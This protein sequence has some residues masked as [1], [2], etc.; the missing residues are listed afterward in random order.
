LK[1]LYLT[2]KLAL[3]GAETLLMGLANAFAGE[4]GFE[5]RVAAA[6]GPLAGRFDSRVG[7]HSITEYSAK[8]APA[9]ALE[10]RRILGETRPD[11]VHAHGASIGALCAA[12]G[13]TKT[14]RAPVI[15]TDHNRE[16][17]RLR[18]GLAAGVMKLCFARVVA[19]SEAKYAGL[20]ALGIPKRKLARIPNFVDCDSV[21][22][23]IAAVDAAAV[24][25]ELGIEQGEP[26]LLTAGR[27]L[28][29]KR[30]DR[31]IE[32][33]ARYGRTRN[34]RPHALI[35]GDG[36]E[37]ARLE[38]SA[39]RHSKNARV[40]LLGYQ[41]DVYKYLAVADAFLFPTDHPE[42]L[43]MVLIEAQAAG[44][45]VVCS[46]IPG[47]D[48]IVVDGRTGFLVAGDDEAYCAR[49]DAA[50]QDRSR[51]SRQAEA[52]ARE[53]FDKA[54]VIKKHLELYRSL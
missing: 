22:R 47:N 8:K 24:R 45:P 12:A 14:R 40:K 13:W 17:T 37:R 11:A 39:K 6:P 35:L 4:K 44:V 41:P 16:A 1:L 51:F 31:F 15:L 30:A 20:R 38:D 49:L 46:D 26:V 23:K 18:P 50:L 25:A 33:A 48:E 29:L 9:I 10:L 42:V 28:P 2:E 52:H 32:I 7:I 54:L 53:R 19:I 36:P 21:A 34:A 5:V 3:G 43:P 27:L